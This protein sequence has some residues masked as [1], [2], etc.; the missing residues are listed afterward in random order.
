VRPL[1]FTDCPGPG[2]PGAYIASN[3]PRDHLLFGRMIPC[4][5]ALRRRADQIRAEM[6]NDIRRMTFA[7]FQPKPAHSDALKA[8]RAM[9]ADAWGQAWCFLTLTGTNREGK[10]HLAAAIVNDLLDRGEPA[11]FV[12]APNFLRELRSGFRDGSFEQRFQ[13]ALT[14][15]VL[16]LDDLGAE[17]SGRADATTAI[18]WA[19]DML[20]QL[21]NERLIEQRPTVFTTNAPRKELSARIQARLWDERHALAVPIVRN[22]H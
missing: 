4:V 15:P 12:V 11:L 2:C 1:R 16:V 14:A 17:Q 3:L 6:P 5:C 20:Y 21:I 13:A 10:T 7:A 18:T 22:G 19:D 8:T 9:A